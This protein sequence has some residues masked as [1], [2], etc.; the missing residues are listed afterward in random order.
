MK[1]FEQK[2]KF[3]NLRPKMFYL[4]IVRLKFEKNCCYILNN[5]PRFIG[6]EKFCRN[7]KKKKEKRKKKIKKIKAW[8]QKYVILEFLEC[9]FE[10][11][12]SYGKSTLSRFPKRK[13]TCKNENP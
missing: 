5:H 6:N 7:Q 1:S 2:L 10:K 11:L 12:L 4:C 13:V 9:Y 8:D 3:L